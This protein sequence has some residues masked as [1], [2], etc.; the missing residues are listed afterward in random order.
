MNTD[1]TSIA[2]ET[3]DYGPCAF[4]DSFHP[5]T[6]YS[7]IDYAGRYAY[8]N[9]P[10]IGLWNMARLAEAL[11]PLLGDDNDSAVAAARAALDAYPVQFAAAYHAGLRAKLGLTEARDDD[12]ALAKALLGAMAAGEADFTLTWRRLCDA[13]ETGEAGAVR[14]L[15]KD[16]D[17]FDAWFAQWRARLDDEGGV[18]AARAAAMRAVNPAFIPRNHQVQAAITAALGGDF[19]VFEALLGVLARPFDDQPEAALFAL[20]PAPD[21]VVRQTFC[22]T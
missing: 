14:A 13:A 20:P 22:G 3:I 17:A 21:E 6:V 4:M 10:R 5:D 12:V 18:S 8:G 1:N 7:S 19:S 16:A 9:Q 2:G 11:L 15:F